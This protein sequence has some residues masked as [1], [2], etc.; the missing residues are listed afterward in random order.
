MKNFEN[1]SKIENKR[2]SDLN[3]DELGLFTLK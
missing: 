3:E 2:F 1:Y